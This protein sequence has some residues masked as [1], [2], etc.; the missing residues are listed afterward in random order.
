MVTQEPGHAQRKRREYSLMV[1]YLAPRKVR[2]VEV[3]FKLWILEE[4]MMIS[5]ESHFMGFTD[6]LEYP[7]LM[8][9]PVIG[10]KSRGE[11]ASL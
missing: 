6:S 4:C 8:W 7:H 1:G 2:D 10:A 3:Y 9:L 11:Q 5:K